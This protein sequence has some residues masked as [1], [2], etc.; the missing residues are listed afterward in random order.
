MVGH[1]RDG[2]F[3]PALRLRGFLLAEPGAEVGHGRRR[4]GAVPF[5]LVCGDE[6]AQ[7][8]EIEQPIFDTPPS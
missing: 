4:A 8:F 7:G 2:V 3:R 6:C 5:L 1:D